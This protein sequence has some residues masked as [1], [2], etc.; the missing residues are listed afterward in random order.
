MNDTPP[1]ADDSVTITR[2]SLRDGGW[3][4]YSDDA[5]FIDDDNRRAKI[6]NSD[7]STIGLRVVEWDVAVMS[8]L[9]VVLGGYVVVTRN[10]LI[11]LAFALVGLGSLYRTYT[12]RYELIIHV[13]NE[14]KPVTVYPDHPTECHETLADGLGMESVSPR[15]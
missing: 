8:V 2:M 15:D 4:G 10:P 12:K 5:V 11:G 7:I 1:P 13:E 3:I 6:R 9:L 14:S